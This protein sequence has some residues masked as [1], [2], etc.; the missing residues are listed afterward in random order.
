MDLGREPGSSSAYNLAA[1]L[2]RMHDKMTVGVDAIYEPIWGRT[3]Q[4]GKANDDR[5]RFSNRIVRG[6]AS[7]DFPLTS[8]DNSIRF[9]AG[10]QLKA[11]RY[12]LDQVDS[13]ETSQATAEHWN[14]WTHSW[15]FSFI[16]RS[17]EVH[18]LW[19]VRSGTSRP[20]TE[21]SNINGSQTSVLTPVRT[22]TEL[23]SITV[24]IR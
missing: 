1:G 24:P 23:F 10:I 13:V 18:C 16:T 14:E 8:P 12:R 6:G 9:M 5:Y 15:G 22:F 7:R 21:F 2:S 19:R 20:G 3:S 17:V 4:T 11:V